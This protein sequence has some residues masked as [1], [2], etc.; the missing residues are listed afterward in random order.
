L[1]RYRACNLMFGF[2]TGIMMGLKSFC[3]FNSLRK[4]QLLGFYDRLQHIFGG[5]RRAMVDHKYRDYYFMPQ[6]EI[7]Q[8]ELIDVHHYGFVVD[9][10]SLYRLGAEPASQEM[11]SAVNNILADHVYFSTQQRS[12]YEKILKL[13]DFKRRDFYSFFENCFLSIP[14][15][16]KFMALGFSEINPKEKEINSLSQ[17]VF[18]MAELMRGQ[19]YC[20]PPLTTKPNFSMKNDAAQVPHGARV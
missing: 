10:C 18:Y 11:I 6:Y 2:N 9:M 14:F 17:S 19:E 16:S 13:A 5:C 20:P 3:E 7:G 4:N 15:F 8:Q 12:D 1:R